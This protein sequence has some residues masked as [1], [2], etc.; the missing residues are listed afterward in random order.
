MTADLREAYDAIRKVGNIFLAFN[1]NIDNIIHVGRD[2]EKLA[3]DC[4]P[5]KAT[6]LKN[7]RD[8]ISGIMYSMKHGESMEIPM[9][10][11]LE[12][13]VRKNVKERD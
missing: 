7:R 2:L 5:A 8:L 12:E 3:D 9:D 10:R 4:I 6:K 13:W 11:D 1:S